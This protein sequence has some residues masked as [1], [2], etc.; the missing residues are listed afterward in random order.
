ML[1]RMLLGALRSAAVVF[2][3]TNAVRVLLDDHRLV[4]PSRLVY[5]PYGVAPEFGIE[6]DPRDGAS[7]LLAPLG[8]RPFVLHVGS[9]VRRKRLDLLLDVF[10]RLRAQNPDLR[11]VQQGASLS[12]TQSAQVAA[13]GIGDALFQPPKVDRQTLAGLYRRA[14]VVLVTSASEGFGFPVIEALACGAKVVASDIPPLREVGAGGAVF[15]PVGDVTTWTT[16]VN[17]ILKGEA[18][19][20]R[21]LRIACAKRFSWTS[22]ARTILDAYR[23]V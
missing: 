15:A 8:G 6:D 1:A 3:S 23:S 9:G 14:A 4:D 16:I 12:P 5:A 7:K 11:L 20:D 21:N 19:P 2:Y 17:G 10:A 18:V 22:H 13:L